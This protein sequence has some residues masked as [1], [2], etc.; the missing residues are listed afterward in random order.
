MF[1]FSKTLKALIISKIHK[2]CLFLLC[3]I[4]FFSACKKEK[5]EKKLTIVETPVNDKIT[6]SLWFNKDTGFF[7]GGRKS[8]MGYIYRTVDGGL[9]WTNVYENKESC[10]HDILFVNDTLGYCCGENMMILKTKDAG[11]NWQSTGNAVNADQFFNGTLYSIVGS[12]Q[13]L[14]FVGGRNF[15]VGILNR[16][17]NGRVIGGFKGFSN[18]LRSGFNFETNNYLVCGYGTSYATSDEGN[19][20]LPTDM[21]GDFFTSC[22]TLNASTGFACGYNGGIYK[23]TG[24]G[25]KQEKIKD[26]NRFYQKSRNFTGIVFASD[27]KGWVCGN[28]GLLYQTTDGELFTQM[29]VETTNDLLSVA[30]NKNSELIVSTVNGKLIKIPY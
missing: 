23:I 13:S 11:L 1:Y 16:Y 7:C 25:T 21:T 4:L 17:V 27:T 20:F 9:T 14:F 18:E 30:L 8:A 26:H 5:V 12:E 22:F 28:A 6:K 2:Y 15:N 24:A 3:F 10:L 19:T 29:D